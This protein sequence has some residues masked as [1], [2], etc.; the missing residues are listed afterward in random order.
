MTAPLLRLAVLVSG[1]GTNLQNIIELSQ[2]GHL[3]ATV[4]LVVSDNCEAYALKRADKAGIKTFVLNARDYASRIEFDRVLHQ[5]IEPSKPDLIVLAGFMRILSAEFVNRYEN[6]IVNIHP[7][8]L[9]KHKGMNTHEKVLMNKD[10]YHGA[11]VHFVTP[12]LDAGP[13]ILQK[14][15]KVHPTDTISTL[16]QRVHQ[17]EYEIYPRAIQMIAEDRLELN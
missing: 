17:I 12:K 13:I 6:R 7:S 5:T 3:S 11:T 4:D 2:S 15:I 10:D 14:S 1:S 8:L 16:K 9:P